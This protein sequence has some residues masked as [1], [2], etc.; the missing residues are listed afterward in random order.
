MQF[1]EKGQLPCIG[2]GQAHLVSS[3]I[4]KMTKIS[5]GVE[6]YRDGSFMLWCLSMAQGSSALGVVTVLL[7]LKRGAGGGV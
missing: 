7:G 3:R 1:Q 2:P 6:E 4:K 5:L